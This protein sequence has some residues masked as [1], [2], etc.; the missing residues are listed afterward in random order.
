[1]LVERMQN[2][3]QNHLNAGQAAQYLGVARLTLFNWAA[4][5]QGPVHIHMGARRFY[6][7]E[8]LDHFLKSCEVH[9]E[10]GS[11]VS[12]VALDA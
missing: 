5:G 6:K 7:R 9:T 12:V 10:C 2:Q 1:M 3:L 8:D 4:K 11:A